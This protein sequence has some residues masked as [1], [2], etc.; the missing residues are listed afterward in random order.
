MAATVSSTATSSS[1]PE[2]EGEGEGERELEEQEEEAREAA[3][4]E[5][6]QAHSTRID[7]SSPC[8]MRKPSHGEVQLARSIVPN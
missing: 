6:A 1:P 7:P 8:P 2:L 3:F 4:V 5:V